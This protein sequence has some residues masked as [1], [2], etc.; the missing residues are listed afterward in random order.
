MQEARRF[1]VVPIHIRYFGDLLRG[2]VRVLNFPDDGEVTAAVVDFARDA[3]L[4]RVET[5]NAAA[6]ECGHIAPELPLT[7]ARMPDPRSSTGETT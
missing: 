5:Q 1:V 4:L 3:V 7:C 2:R 6:V